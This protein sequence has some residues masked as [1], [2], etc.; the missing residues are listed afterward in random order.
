MSVRNP[1]STAR[2]A[3]HPIHPMLVP[4]PIA[5]LVGAFL[6]DLAFW[7]GRDSFWASASLYL[8]GA[9]LLF[10]A[11]AALAGFADFFGDKA[12]R[13]LGAARKHMI[14]NLTLVVLSVVNFVLRLGDPETAVVPV[15]LALS[16][17]VVLMLLYT[18]W[19]GG[20][21]VYRHRVGIPD[22]TA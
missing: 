19:K 11:L 16:G 10:A 21:L 3:G 12:V 14:G 20:E 18:G 2:I 17:I 1:H 13:D 5:F 9:A 8:L 7:Q 6:S 4:F 22:E 15:G